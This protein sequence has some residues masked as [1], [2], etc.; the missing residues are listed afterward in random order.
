MNDFILTKYQV[1]INAIKS[2]IG[3]IT[4]DQRGVLAANNMFHEINHTIKTNASGPFVINH[5]IFQ[6][7]FT[8]F[9]AESINSILN[10]TINI[11]T[12][13]HEAHI[14]DSLISPF[15][16]MAE[17]MKNNR[18]IHHTIKSNFCNESKSSFF[19]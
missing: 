5:V 9:K 12:I 18:V 2:N 10:H 14:N 1:I 7:H 19:I 17:E 16:I 8:F 15:I 13:I 3:F 6:T 11:K 4:F